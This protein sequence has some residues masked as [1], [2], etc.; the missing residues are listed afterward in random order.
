M[1]KLTVAVDHQ[2][3]RQ[4]AAARLERLLDKVKARNAEHMKDYQEE[5]TESGARFSFSVM[6]FSVQGEVRVLD[7]AVQV[8]C[9]LPLAAM[10]F[11]GRI[12]RDIR[13]QLEKNLR[14][15]SV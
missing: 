8:D 1:P 15:E 9:E 2:L 13:E 12:E 7:S 11:K 3:G 14:S 6:G 10:L 4:E 5:R